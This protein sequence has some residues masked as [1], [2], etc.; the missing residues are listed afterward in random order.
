MKT[1][2]NLCRTA[3]LL[4]LALAALAAPA[5]AEEPQPQWIVVTAPAFRDTLKPLIEQ[6]Q[7]QGL[8]VVVVPTTDVLSPKELQAGDAAK[9]R[10]H[11][12]KLC[13]DHAGVSYVLL[14]GAV[15]ADDGEAAVKTV[16]P[17]LPGTASRMKGQPSD[18]GYGCPGEGLEPTVAVG[19]FPARSAR[20]C[21]AMVDKTLAFE[22]DAS[23]GPWRRQLTVL[24]GIPA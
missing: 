15:K 3:V 20:E 16:V 23:P 21:Q 17:P 24:A 2:Q 12:N 6:R 13:R 4:A 10:E 1:L 19:R 18:N 11:V 14:A 9:L 7:A 22:K 5:R 8:R